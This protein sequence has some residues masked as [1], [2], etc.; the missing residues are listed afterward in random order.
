M[1]DRDFEEVN[2]GTVQ[3]KNQQGLDSYESEIFRIE[4]FL[5]RGGWPVEFGLHR[6]PF[7]I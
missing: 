2:H 3:Q 4:R 5:K 1:Q 7:G 6:Q